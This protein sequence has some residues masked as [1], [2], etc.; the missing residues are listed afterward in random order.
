MNDRQLWLLGNMRLTK[1]LAEMPGETGLKLTSLT[2]RYQRTKEA[3]AAVVEEVDAALVCL[4]CGGQCCHNGKYRINVF[5]TMARIAAQLT[6]SADFTQIPLCPYGSDRGCYM[7]PGQRPA[8]CVLF[9]CDAID[10]KLSPQARSIIMEQE[11]ILRD[12]I[13]EASYLTGERLGAPLLLWADKNGA[14][15]QSKA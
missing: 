15:L 7:E 6:T 12:C 4:E 14:T 1:L 3:L 5:D 11:Q 9:I 10:R 2:A 8:D 13:R